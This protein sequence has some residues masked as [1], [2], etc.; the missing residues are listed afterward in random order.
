VPQHCD[1]DLLALLALG[2]GAAGPADDEHLRSCPDCRDALADLRR[3][4]AT[5]RAVEPGD[6][7]EAPPPTVWAGIRDELGLTGP[8]PAAV[9]PAPPP[10]EPAGPDGSHWP[11]GPPGAPTPAAPTRH[12]GADL[13]A[14]DPRGLDRRRRDRRLP[15]PWLLA[16]AAVAGLGL[17][18][19]A[20]LALVDR[21]AGTG[22]DVVATA[23]LEPLPQWDATGSAALVV[24]PGGARRL[25]V[26]LTAGGD[27]AD[28]GGFHEVWLLTTDVSGLVSL[29]V[30]D[31]ATGSFPIPAGLDLA[32]FPVVDVSLEP[33]DGDPAHSGD[34]VVR[35][36][37]AG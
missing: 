2:E 7:L 24:E 26:D 11:A 16:A 32:Q 8:D 23:R 4:V 30:L 5:G 27:P 18:A 10:A 19:A 3:V 9:E 36:S 15:R 29:G 21:F 20:T 37:L 35:G 14:P 31:G 12:A 6:A 17:G 1:P 13:R 22:G 33:L 28:P 34:S 25:D